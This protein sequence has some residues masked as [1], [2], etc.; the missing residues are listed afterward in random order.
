MSRSSWEL[1]R[2]DLGFI[3]TLRRSL[4]GGR[5]VVSTHYG[6][7]PKTYP[8]AFLVF[9]VRKKR[10]SLATQRILMDGVISDTHIINFTLPFY[11]NKPC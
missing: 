1:L 2:H 11:E 3:D 7:E 9:H 5:Y 8:A 4:P 6:I 10:L